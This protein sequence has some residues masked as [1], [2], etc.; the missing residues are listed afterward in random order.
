M[1]ERLILCGGVRRTGGDSILRLALS[2]RSQNITLRLE[3]I[4][5]KLIRNVPGRLTDLVEIAAYVYCARP[6]IRTVGGY[7]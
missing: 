1:S 3:D 4:S 6:V 7:R 2:G 5:R